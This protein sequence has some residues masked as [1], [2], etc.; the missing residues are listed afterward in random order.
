MVNDAK[1]LKA[2]RVKA[3]GRQN[4]KGFVV[5][6]SLG[7]MILYPKSRTESDA[8][9]NALS[10]VVAARRSAMCVSLLQLGISTKTRMRA[11][12]KYGQ[13]PAAASS[14]AITVGA[15]LYDDE[16]LYNSNHGKWQ[17]CARMSMPRPPGCY[18]D[19]L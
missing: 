9:N 18:T 15:T 5:N 3:E 12:A 14:L 16:R 7:I 17:M 2:A 10:E 6:M 1:R 19:R 11:S 13:W 4:W 8:L